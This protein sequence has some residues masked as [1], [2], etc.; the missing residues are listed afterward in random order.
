[1]VAGTNSRQDEEDFMKPQL[2]YSIAE[3]CA[4]A[5]VGRTTLSEAIRNGSLRAVKRGARTLILAEDLRD[6]IARLPA[7]NSNHD[8]LNAFSSA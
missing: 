8:A 2:V 5:S 4:A 7:K 1:V 3:A 6:W